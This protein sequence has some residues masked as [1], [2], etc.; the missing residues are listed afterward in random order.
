MPTNAQPFRTL[1]EDLLTRFPKTSKQKLKLMATSGRVLVNGIP[2]RKLT[3]RIRVDAEVTILDRAQAK[4]S[5]PELNSRGPR[6]RADASLLE[7]IY[8]DEDVLVVNKP[9][10]LLTSTTPNEPRPTL[11]KLI[12]DHLG[13]NPQGN[14]IRRLGLIHR[15]DRDARGL[16]IFSKSSSAYLSLKAQFKVHSVD[17][18]YLAMVKGKPNPPAGDLK[19]RLVELPDGTVRSSRSAQKGEVALA[20]YK[21]LSAIKDLSLVEVKLMTGRKHQIRVQL[22]ERGWPIVG[23]TVYRRKEFKPRLGKVTPDSPPPPKPPKPYSPLVQKLDTG[24]LRLIAIRLGFDHP[25]TGKRM[26]FELPKPD[27]MSLPTE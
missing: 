18:A 21:V 27:D 17:R 2:V 11:L 25:V 12:R 4:P 3:A 19:S 1:L 7:V 16:I 13:P 20:Q 15:L 14:R 24:L 8:E 9:A 6:G 26:I 5:R 23:D 22:S 10:G